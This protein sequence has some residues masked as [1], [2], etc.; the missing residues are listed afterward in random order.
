[1]IIFNPFLFPK[2]FKLNPVFINYFFNRF[3]KKFD[4]SLGLRLK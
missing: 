1:L 2:S 3:D 4:V